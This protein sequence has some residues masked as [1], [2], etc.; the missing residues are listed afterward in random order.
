VDPLQISLIVAGHDIF[1]VFQQEK[2]TDCPPKWFETR[3]SGR[4][5]P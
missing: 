1:A 5:S 3:P 2:L 4:F